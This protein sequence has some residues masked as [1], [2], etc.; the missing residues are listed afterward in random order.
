[1]P[2]AADQMV[3]RPEA[4]VEQQVGAHQAAR[5]GRAGNDQHGAE[6]H[7]AGLQ[8][9][10][11][12]PGQ[13]GES[14][15]CA[16]AARFEPANAVAATVGPAL[17]DGRK[18]AQALDEFGL[19]QA[20]GEQSSVGAT[21]VPERAAA[22]AGQ[23]FRTALARIRAGNAGNSE[24][25]K[26]RMQHEQHDDEKRRAERVE[27]DGDGAGGSERLNSL[28]SRASCGPACASP[29]AARRM[30]SSSTGPLRRGR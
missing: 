26:S 6:R 22:G 5:R 17:A 27:G 21:A 9:E 13:A 1:M 25:A 2:P 7:H 23:P 29:L 4:L 20:A 24:K 8:R 28:T 30:P 12:E 19:G 3:E 15:C 14:T 10:A 18:H 16:L 11:S